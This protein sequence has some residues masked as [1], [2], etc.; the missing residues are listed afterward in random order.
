MRKKANTPLLYSVFLFPKK[1]YRQAQAFV[2]LEERNWLE[3]YL[4]KYSKRNIK[5]GRIHPSTSSIFH[6]DTEV[7]FRHMNNGLMNNVSDD[8]WVFIKE[9]PRVFIT[10]SGFITREMCD[11][12]GVSYVNNMHIS[13][14]IKLWEGKQ[15]HES[16]RSVGGTWNGELPFND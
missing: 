6:Y 3:V 11:A 2:M 10:G 15:M 9:T 1:F 7:F 8:Y 16:I 12:I 14:A 5:D 4:R 13:K